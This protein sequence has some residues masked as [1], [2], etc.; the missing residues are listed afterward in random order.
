MTAVFSSSGATRV[1]CR[2]NLENAPKAL[3]VPLSRWERAGV[4]ETRHDR[5][6]FILRGDA[7]VLPGLATK[8]VP[9]DASGRWIL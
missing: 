4:R 5:R 2:V 9:R 7:G 3:L 1:S 8:Q 6:V